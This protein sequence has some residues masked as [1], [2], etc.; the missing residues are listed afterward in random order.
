MTNIGISGAMGR[1]GMQLVRLVQADPALKLV[2]ALEY[3]GHEAI[4]R[5]VGLEHGSGA[6]GV[7]LAAEMPGGVDVLVDFSTPDG[8]AR[9]LEA[10][11]AA[12]TAIVIGTTGIEDLR[13]KIEEAEKQIAILAS[14]N[15]SVGVNLLF[16]VAAQIARRLGSEYDIEIIEA[17]HRFKK[18]APSG[19]ALKIAQEIA[20]AT[21]RALEKD[22]VF[23]RHG[24]PLDR[25]PGEIGMHAVRGGDIVGEHIVMYAALGERVELKHVAQSRETFARGALRA[26]KHLHGKKPGLYAM[27]D[28][29]AQED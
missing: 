19:T 23:G 24:K 5:D 1:M 22:A 27:A 17:H 21:G 11:M 8:T 12:G 3:K 20:A 15:M 16:S 26:A 29:L 25:A 10:C 28:V 9:H 7:K 13:Q 18:D 4:G 14:P 6:A 2:A